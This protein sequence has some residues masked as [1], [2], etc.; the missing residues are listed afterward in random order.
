LPIMVSTARHL[1]SLC[2][3]CL[4]GLACLPGLAWAAPDSL[5]AR[6]QVP[7]AHVYASPSTT[8]E[9]L[10]LLEKGSAVELEKCKSGWCSVKTDQ[11]EGYVRQVELSFQPTDLVVGTA[12][13]VEDEAL[14]G[15]VAE[16]PRFQADGTRLWLVTLGLVQKPR[17][18]A[19]SLLYEIS[20]EFGQEK[21][22]PHQVACFDLAQSQ[23]DQSPSD[24]LPQLI[25]GNLAPSSKGERLLFEKTLDLGDGKPQTTFELASATGETLKTLTTC[26]VTA[27]HF[28]GKDSLLFL[29]PEKTTSRLELWLYSPSSGQPPERLVLPESDK[30]L[31]LG[32]SPSP[33]GE[34]VALLRAAPAAHRLEVCLMELASQQ[35][36]V[37]VVL[38]GIRPPWTLKWLDETHVGVT[39]IEDDT[40][41]AMGVLC[42]TT[43][44]DTPPVWWDLGDWAEFLPDER[45][46]LVVQQGQVFLRPLQNPVLVQL[47]GSPEV[48]E[49][50]PNTPLVALGPAGQQVAC[51]R[52]GV[53][54]LIQLTPKSSAAP[55]AVSGTSDVSTPP[56]PPADDG[57]E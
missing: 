1:F 25:I 43:T 36:K 26:A 5:V 44:K 50:A 20:L 3:F 57:E 15:K 48:D 16:P 32:C 27:P 9:V 13:R 53:L 11:G 4:V 34:Q 7:R 19:R 6:V 31:Y 49:L 41:H 39:A 42:D 22:E 46:F 37:R 45:G 18:H 55:E 47:A 29:A 56:P 2:L 24:Y 14:Q 12:L 35:F 17:P 28:I 33:Q 40:G 23:L 38:E 8:A 54:W 52:K 10:A 51:V 30:Y 21:L